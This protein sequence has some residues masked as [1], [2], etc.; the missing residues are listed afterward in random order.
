MRAFSLALS[1][2]LI[3]V[4][5]TAMPARAQVSDS[6]QR[7]GAAVQADSTYANKPVSVTDVL[8]ISAFLILF[9]VIPLIIIT[10]CLVLGA[11]AVIAIL[12]IFFAM[13]TAGF[14]ATPVIVA[15][16]E[17]SFTKGFRV[18]IL[19]LSTAGGVAVGM[20]TLWILNT[21]YQWHTAATAIGLG[22]LTGLVTGVSFGFVTLYI[23]KRLT[24]YF[25]AKLGLR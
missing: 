14:I 22:M 25:K 3:V 24:T 9:F 7:S 20:I 19:L 4:L 5:I 13:V 8:D 17:R 6:L 12:F 1:I 10:S 23:V 18:F 16:Y 15:L 2:L 11:V 21:I